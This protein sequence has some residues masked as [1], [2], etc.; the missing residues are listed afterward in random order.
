[1]RKKYVQLLFAALLTFILTGCMYPEDKLQQNQIPYED[2]VQS[3]QTAVT[4]FREDNGGIL[5]IKNAEENTPIYQKYKIDF[6]RLVPEYLLNRRAMPMKAA[7]F[8]NMY[9]LM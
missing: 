1:M 5:P 8:F 6:K 9:L 7:V 3:V 4:K 2:Q